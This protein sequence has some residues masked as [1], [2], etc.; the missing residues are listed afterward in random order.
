MKILKPIGAKMAF[1]NGADQMTPTVEVVESTY[2]RRK[3]GDKMLIINT[4]PA[5]HDCEIAISVDTMIHIVA[6]AITP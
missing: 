5:G 4:N 1:T 2:H 6:W 3:P